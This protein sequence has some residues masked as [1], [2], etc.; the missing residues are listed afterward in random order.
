MSC[1]VLSEMNRTKDVSETQEVFQQEN[2]EITE[3]KPDFFVNELYGKAYEKTEIFDRSLSGKVFYILSGHGGID[4]GAVYDKGGGML[5]EDEYAYDVALRLSRNLA[6]HG[7]IVEMV[8]QDDDGIRDESNLQCDT[9]EVLANGKRIPGSQRLRLKQRTLYVNDKYVQYQKKGIYDQYLVSIHVDSRTATH[10]QDV[11]FCHYKES[12]AGKKLASSLQK[13]FQEMYNKHQKNRGYHGHVDERSFYVLM[14]TAPPATLIELA[15]I[16]NT[17]DHKRIKMK[18]NRQALAN[19][20][21]EGLSDHAIAES[22][23]HVATP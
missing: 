7:A 1:R 8:I 17:H 21:F 15:N 18:E 23:E 12:K 5:C 19:W 2:V 10:R 14:N 4:P 16:K 9:D 22:Q 11:F 6:Q 13:K 20:I 3:G